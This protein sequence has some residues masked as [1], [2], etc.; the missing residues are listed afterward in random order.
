MKRR[1]KSFLWLGV[2]LATVAAVAAKILRDFHTTVRGTNQD[3]QGTEPMTVR[4]FESPGRLEQ[5]DRTAP[6]YSGFDGQL[7]PLGVQYEA[8]INRLGIG[9]RIGPRLQSGT[10]PR[11]TFA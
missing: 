9:R 3:L 7:R 2:A 11:I 5:Q 6:W 1:W 10:L 4:E 8:P